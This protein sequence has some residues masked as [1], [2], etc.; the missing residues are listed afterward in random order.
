M[1]NAAS[2]YEGFVHFEKRIFGCGA[3]QDNRAVF[4]PGQQSVLLAFIPAV[5]FVNKQNGAPVVEFALFVRMSDC[6]A[7]MLHAGKNGVKRNE[8][9]FCVIGDN[10]GEGCFS[11]ARRPV[12]NNGT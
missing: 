9:A 5:N 2:A 6:V 12:K 11:G 4:D 7:D 1:E 10:A 8:I 3:D